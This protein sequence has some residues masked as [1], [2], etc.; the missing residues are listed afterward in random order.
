MT[1]LPDLPL[2]DLFVHFKNLSS[3][4]Y[5]Q[6]LFWLIGLD[7]IT[8]C[9]KF[10]RTHT[11]DSKISSWGMLKHLLVF[12]TVLIVATYARALGFRPIGIA[13]CVHFILSY[14]G[15]ILENWEQIGLF[16]PPFLEPYLNQLK[17][18]NGEF[19]T[20]NKNKAVTIKADNIATGT[21]Q[22]ETMKVD[23][24]EGNIDFIK[25]D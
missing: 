12:T 9:I 25:E 18:K 19:Y 20:A 21:M 2:G 16:F 3:S 5:I 22:S 24:G 13:F 23:L 15:S 14:I 7:I 6:L 10:L 17:K 4:P 8:G 1:T 11:F